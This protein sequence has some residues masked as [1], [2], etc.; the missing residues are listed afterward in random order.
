MS[1]PLELTEIDWEALKADSNLVVVEGSQRTGSQYHFYMETQA[2]IA[3]PE[4]GGKL[5][6]YAS[7]QSPNV[8]QSIVAKVC[9]LPV[10][11]VTVEV[12]QQ[13]T[14]MSCDR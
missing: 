14:C 7:T 2:T 3:Y 5:K 12:Q 11:A 6:V 4:E 9:D 8:I 10:H 1:R 13:L